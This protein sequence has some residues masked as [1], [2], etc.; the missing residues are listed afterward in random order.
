MVAG[1]DDV[2]AHL[3]PG[4][5]RRV[6]LGEHADAVAIHH[7]GVAVHLDLAGELAVRGVVAGEVGVGLGVPEV[8]HRHDLDVVLLAALVVGA[9][10]VAADAAIAVDGDLD[11]HFLP[12]AM[13]A[14]TV[15]TTLS[16]VNPKCL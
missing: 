9:E 10:D 5:L 2:H 3:A 12:L 7:H 4:E 13:T 11:G 8:V 16:T 14:L 6:A 1:R 15:A